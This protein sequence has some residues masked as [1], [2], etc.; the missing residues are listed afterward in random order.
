ML[1]SCALLALSILCCV[2]AVTG[3]SGPCPLEI[4]FRADT[5]TVASLRCSGHTFN[6]VPQD[7]QFGA[8]RS[9]PGKIPPCRLAC[10]ASSAAELSL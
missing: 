8:N 5:G 10:L 9:L 2:P 6:F 1:A 4:A 7:G 3:G